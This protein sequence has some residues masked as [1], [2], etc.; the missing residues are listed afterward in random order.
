MFQDTAAIPLVAIIPLLAANGGTSS[1]AELALSI[2]KIV[3]AIV[4]V[5]LLVQNVS[6]PVLRFVARSGLREMFSAV[7][8]F[9]INLRD[10]RRHRYVYLSKNCQGVKLFFQGMKNRLHLLTRLAPGR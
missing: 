4:A 5:V 1:G 10:R 6:Q 8:L 9:L 7:A 2:A 3:G